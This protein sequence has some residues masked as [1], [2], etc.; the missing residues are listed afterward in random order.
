MTLNIVR[1]ALVNILMIIV[2]FVLQSAV[3]GRLRL[4]GVSPNVLLILTASCAIMRG[5]RSGLLMGFFCGLFADI[6]FGDILGLN[7]LLYM[8]TGFVCGYFRKI[9][10]PENMVLPLTIIA[11]SDLVYAF[12]SYVFLFLLRTRLNIGFYMGHVIV[13]EVLYTVIAALLVY[14]CILRVYLYLEDVEQRSAK[15]FV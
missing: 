4:A 1:R 15:K 11:V 13:P 6:F 7:A 3:F 12:L 14:P 2:C 5:R 8:Y 10:Y 9:Y